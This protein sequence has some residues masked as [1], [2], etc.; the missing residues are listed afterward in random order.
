[1]S[2]SET[3]Y[4]RLTSLMQA[5]GESVNGGTQTASEFAAFAKGCELVFSSIDKVF[6]NTFID[7]AGELG[8]RRICSLLEM[9]KFDPDEVKERFSALYSEYA[10]GDMAREY[11]KY[12]SRNSV[13]CDNF[14][15]SV[16]GYDDAHKD[17][18]YKIHPF[19]EKY[20]CPGVV[21]K[22][23]G[24]AYTFDDLDAFDLDCNQWDKI[25]LCTFNFIDSLGGK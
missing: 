2:Y 22:L 15:L 16:T 8:R 17:G 7:T 14:V 5:L 24:A 18:L 21:A 25:G 23:S 4:A 1:M 12:E 3:V 10:S 19:F 11:A 20:L 9:N 13:K 6:S